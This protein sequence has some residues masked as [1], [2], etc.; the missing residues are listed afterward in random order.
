MHSPVSNNWSDLGRFWTTPNVLSMLRLVLVLPLAWLIITEG[1]L[2]WIMII[3]VLAI[4]T[5]YF[6]GRIARWS[7]TESEWGKVLDPMADKIGG[8]MVVAALTFQ[9]SIP[10]WFLIAL[11]IRDSAILVGGGIIRMRTGRILASMWSGKVAV[12]AV[13][14]TASAALLRA[15]APV[16][17]FCLWASAV[18]LAYSFI[19]Y[20]VRFFSIISASGKATDSPA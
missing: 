2:F 17:T 7:N 4:A 3:V 20:M 8:G 18:L 16:L 9:G 6:D 14:I 11:A 15:D 19:R 12:T 1:P 10:L 13:A 5:D